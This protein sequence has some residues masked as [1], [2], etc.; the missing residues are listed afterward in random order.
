[1]RRSSLQ[2]ALN[3]YGANWAAEPY[4]DPGPPF[5][6]AEHFVQNDARGTFIKTL[7]EW[8]QRTDRHTAVSGPA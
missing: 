6:G 4:P 1:M 2:G 3:Y 7:A 8:L 5:S